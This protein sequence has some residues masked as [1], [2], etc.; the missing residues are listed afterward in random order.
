[1]KSPLFGITL[2]SSGG[3]MPGFRVGSVRFWDSRTRWANIQERPGVYDWSVLDRL[4]G[5]PQRAGLPTTF[6]IGCTP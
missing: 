1:V 3:Q 4:T 2:S 5:N 6:V